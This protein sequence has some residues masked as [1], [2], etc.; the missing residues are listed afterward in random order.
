MNGKIVVHPDNEI[1]INKKEQIID[2][3]NN[4]DESQKKKKEYILYDSI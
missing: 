3:N 1:L 4:M 2:T